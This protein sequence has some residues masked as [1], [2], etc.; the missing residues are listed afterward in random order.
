MCNL[1]AVL[2]VRSCVP[3]LPPLGSSPDADWIGLLRN[4]RYAIAITLM[5]I[6]QAVL[7]AITLS[8]EVWFGVDPYDLSATSLALM[9]LWIGL[10]SL[11]IAMFL[12]PKLAQRFGSVAVVWMSFLPLLCGLAIIGNPPVL[13]PRLVE[14][15]PIASFAMAL[16]GV[17][18]GLF[19]PNLPS[20]LVLALED[21]GFTQAGTAA[22]NGVNIVITTFGGYLFGSLIGGTIVESV[23]VPMS[24]FVCF[25]LV[26]TSLVLSLIAHA[27]FLGVVPVDSTVDVKE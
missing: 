23:G 1:L 26:G 25:V 8:T 18:A 14:T 24:A 16:L 21:A 12:A 7:L 27:K 17:A 22:G 19:V 11:P 5:F 2:F 10:T 15:I 13:F 3:N 20:L 9:P 4:W 6:V